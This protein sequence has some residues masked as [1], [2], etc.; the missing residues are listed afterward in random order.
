MEIFVASL[1]VFAGF[2]ALIAGGEFL[3]RSSSKFASA[4]GIS[5]VVAGLTV[6]A[7]ATSAPE[8]AVVT[9]AAYAGKTDLAIGNAV[10]SNIFNVLFVL[11]VSAMVAPLI[12]KDQLIRF[13]VPAM[14]GASILL[15]LFSL[16]GA[17]GRIDGIIMLALLV[18]YVSWTIVQSRKT[19]NGMV[20][21]MVDQLQLGATPA[22]PL[23]RQLWSQSLWIQ[24]IIFLAGLGLLVIGANWAVDGSVIIA[25]SFG[26]SEL[27]I[28]LTV[29]AIGTSLPEVVTS[30]VASYRGERDIAVGNVIGSNM[31][32]I[33]AVLGLSS[34]VAP[35]GIAVSDN[36]IHFDMP[37]MIAV[38]IACLPVFY[39]G[40]K[41]ARWEGALLFG[42][43]V[44][45]T[46]YLIL[47]SQGHG[48][49]TIL[50]DA[51]VFFVIPLTVLT[52]LAGTY[53]YYRR[54]RIDKTLQSK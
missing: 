2:V 25:K 16:D 29:V 4:F 34:I 20:E 5:S 24:L 23:G 42:Y 30:I 17:L 13:D 7:F 12:V 35:S 40:H 36:A 52:F 53:R 32:N 50:Q 9:Q 1:T 37:V 45:Y 51:M 44:A 31:F 48:Y 38:A 39:I 33:L 28:G 6:V 19:A 18:G 47:R 11:G 54:D 8:L 49:A 22:T 10:G 26:V 3:V 41:I 43:Y 15:L 27:V 21:E 46:S 14:V